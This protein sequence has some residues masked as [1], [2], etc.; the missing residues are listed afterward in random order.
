MFLTS[1]RNDGELTA[2][3]FSVDF[4]GGGTWLTDKNPV[5]GVI[6]NLTNQSLQPKAQQMQLANEVSQRFET[7][8]QQK[9]KKIPWL[10]LHET[11]L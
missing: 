4:G 2:Q 9:A 1:T 8:K 3:N 10:R 6:C 11:Q 5:G 7:D